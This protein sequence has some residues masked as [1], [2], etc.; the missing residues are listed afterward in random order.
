VLLDELIT[1][2]PFH[3]FIPSASV[4]GIAVIII[5][6]IIITVIIAIIIAIIIIIIIIIII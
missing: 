1:G 3:I 2:S 5:I 4:N 6:I